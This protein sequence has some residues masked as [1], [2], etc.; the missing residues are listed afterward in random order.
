[1]E[2]LKMLLQYDYCMRC[3]GY[4][5]DT[6]PLRFDYYYGYAGD[7]TTIRLLLYCMRCYGDRAM[8]LRFDYYY[9]DAG[10]NGYGGDVMEMGILLLYGDATAIRL[11]LWRC[12]R[13]Y[14][15]TIT[16]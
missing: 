4:D 10:M 8:L 12:W 7:A 11:L 14:Y 1:M 6:M 13:C 15:D 16:V 9:G 5:G 2:M 3:Y